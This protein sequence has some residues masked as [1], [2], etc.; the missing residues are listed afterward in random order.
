MPKLAQTINEL[1]MKK[2]VIYRIIFVII[3]YFSV[4][5]VFAKSDVS[6][7]AMERISSPINA[8]AVTSFQAWAPDIASLYTSEP[9][10]SYCSVSDVTTA[11]IIMTFSSAKVADIIQL[12]APN[13][14]MELMPTS[15]SVQASN[16][17][18]SYVTL[19][20][21]SDEPS[22][23]SR[24]CRYFKFVNTTAYKNYKLVLN[25]NAGKTGMRIGVFNYFLSHHPDPVTKW[26]YDETAKTLTR[27]SQVIVKVSNNNGNLVIGDNQTNTTVYDLDLTAGVEGDYTISEIGGTAFNRNQYI[28][29]VVCGYERLNIRWNA[30]SYSWYLRNVH[31][32]EGVYDIG[33]EFVRGCDSLSTVDMSKVTETSL[34]NNSFNGCYNFEGEMVFS[35]TIGTITGGLANGRLTSIKSLNPEAYFDTSMEGNVY[36]TN[37][38]ES[39]IR[40]RLEW[41]NNYLSKL[42]NLE[43]DLGVL[44][45]EVNLNGER[46]FAPE[47]FS[48][49]I[50]GDVYIGR[51]TL[52]LRKPFTNTGITSITFEGPKTFNG[53]YGNSSFVTGCLNLTN[54]LLCAEDIVVG[55]TRLFGDNSKQSFNVYWRSLPPTFVN[56][57][58]IVFEGSTANTIT[59]YI[60][61]HLRN[62][63]YAFAS[64]NELTNFELVLP[65]TFAGDGTWTSGK[66]QVVR[67]WKDPSASL[68]PFIIIVK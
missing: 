48:A 15:F 9:N 39:L 23:L 37:I 21:I 56:T 8:P 32:E 31:L 7:Y 57:N 13:S 53:N 1:H 17:G 58:P 68:P 61:W 44:S 38:Q 19:A 4:V 41:N 28:T 3:A 14:S 35:A 33:N 67:W 40:N 42:P 11:E 59:N 63:W 27:G 50:Y 54:I 24:E 26:V 10:K 29:R 25:T 65:E 12:F 16:D 20:T 64:T 5:N 2:L 60:P 66:K 22:W 43:L 49:K 51:N 6:G 30:F 52:A 47:S 62:E 55:G 34:G 46:T 36:I 45:P 18:D